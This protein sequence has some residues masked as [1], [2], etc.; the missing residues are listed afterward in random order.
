MKL[1][2]FSRNP[3]CVPKCFSQEPWGFNG[4]YVIVRYF[5]FLNQ[6]IALKRSQMGMRLQNRQC[7]VLPKPT[8]KFEPRQKDYQTALEKFINT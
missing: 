6:L 5:H 8:E 4:Q 1:R 7:N 2:L 3:T